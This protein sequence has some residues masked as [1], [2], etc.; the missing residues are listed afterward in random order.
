MAYG[1][2]D[3]EPTIQKF[4][5]MD[6]VVE[7]YEVGLL[8]MRD[9]P[10]IS[11]SLDGIAWVLIP[12]DEFENKEMVLVCVEIKTRVKPRTIFQAEARVDAVKDL[13]VDGERKIVTCVL[14]ALYLFVPFTNH[15]PPIDQM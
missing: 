5:S 4:T 9:H 14:C 8:Q 7:F 11:V 10:T 12:G 15:T 3:M 13:S 1:L 2:F 6:Y